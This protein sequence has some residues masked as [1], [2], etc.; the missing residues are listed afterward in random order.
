MALEVELLRSSFELVVERNPDLTQRFYEIS[1]RALPAPLTDVPSGWRPQ[2]AQMLASALTA[3]L[4][5]LDDADWLGEQ[6]GS[7]GARHVGYGVTNEMYGWVGEALLTTLAEV[8]GDD[9]TPALEQA[10]RT[11]NELSC[12]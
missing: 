2:Q 4:D 3:V 6:L 5:H 9:W 10:G 1:V 11:R 8:A 12:R 7:L